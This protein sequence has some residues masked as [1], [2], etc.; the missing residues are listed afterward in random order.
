MA[1]ESR[2]FGAAKSLWAAVVAASL[3]GVVGLIGLVAD[4]A[5]LDS[6]LTSGG[7]PVARVIGYLVFLVAAGAF[8]SKKFRRNRHTAISGIIA[9]LGAIIVVLSYVLWPKVDT[10]VKIGEEVLGATS[11]PQ[12]IVSEPL[13][14]AVDPRTH[15]CESSWATS[16]RSEDLLSSGSDLQELEDWTEFAP[17]ADG[18]PADFSRI[19][20]TVQGSGPSSVVIT[21]LEVVVLSRNA[22]LGGTV[23]RRPCGGPLVYRYV[24]VD[25]DADRPRAV[26]LELSELA[27]QEAKENGWRIDPVTFPYEVSIQASETFMLKAVT[28]ACDCTWIVKLHWSSNGRTGVL[29]VDNN[30]TP[31][32]TISGNNMTKC[33]I[34]D[35]LT[36]E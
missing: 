36:C 13:A 1:R 30:G 6:W 28:D 17:I 21:E 34:W 12:Q 23:L 8:F 25:L 16:K 20:M 5:Q 26:G 14:I 15:S 3:L 22:P 19:L 29:T 2:T 32:R 35:K 18:A 10:E 9:V 4:L 27:I 7:G 33:D 31:F 11:A 24:D